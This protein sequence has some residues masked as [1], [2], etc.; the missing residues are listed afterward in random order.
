MNISDEGLA[1]I[2]KFEGLRLEA[3]FDSVGVLTIG[4]GHTGQD[5]TEGMKIDEAVADAL[6]RR[7][8]ASAEGCVN[9]CVTVEI[10]QQEFDALVS[11]AFNLGCRTLK[12]STLL[13]KLNASD[14]DG[15]ALEF[16]KW[17]HAGGKELP[18]LV[19]R[20]EAEQA[21]FEATA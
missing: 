11:F 13:R 10:T 21:L 6:L 17:C 8:V 20:R 19:A 1:L 15:A 16:P 5:V 7:D 2:K 4:Y 14:Y 12:N 3:Y 9:G 18:G